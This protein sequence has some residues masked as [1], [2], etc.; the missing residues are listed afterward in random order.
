MTDT[1]QSANTII[2]K[3]T[4]EVRAQARYLDSIRMILE[5]A[6]RLD[7]GALLDA[8]DDDPQYA[9][10]GVF[11]RVCQFEQHWAGRLTT[12]KDLYQVVGWSDLADDLVKFNDV[13]DEWRTMCGFL[14]LRWYHLPVFRVV[15]AGPENSP[16]WRTT[17]AVELMNAIEAVRDRCEA[18]LTDWN[19]DRRYDIDRALL[20]AVC[21][22]RDLAQRYQVATVVDK[23]TNVKYTRL[24]EHAMVD[25][26]LLFDLDACT[27]AVEAWCLKN[28]VQKPVCLEVNPV[29]HVEVVI[30]GAVGPVEDVS[31]TQ[32]ATDEVVKKDE[33]EI[34]GLAPG[35]PRWL[36]IDEGAT[37]RFQMPGGEFTLPKHA[38]E[39]YLSWFVRHM[40]EEIRALRLVAEVRGMGV[41]KELGD[42][43]EDD[44]D[45][46][47]TNGSVNQKGELHP[48][49]VDSVISPE[50]LDGIRRQLFEILAERERCET[51]GNQDRVSK[52]T[53]EVR[54]IEDYLHA[55]VNIR[56]KSRKWSSDD[57][58]A[59]LSI[60]KELSRAYGRVEKGAGQRD[61]REA[62]L[63]HFKDSLTVGYMCKYHAVEGAVVGVL[64]K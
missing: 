45:E 37:Y 63:K 25:R 44:G 64:P 39:K 61:A 49:H 53:E 40:D 54:Q 9:E 36:F 41:K 18:Y 2:D 31:V 33:P 23:L 14:R 10:S 43:V 30:A 32:A 22:L 8:D 7:L 4:V 57:K 47:V 5:G 15:S 13:S 21:A 55:N 12:M 17:L 27:D 38:G 58:K 11:D 3:S 28:G 20:I 59:V 60:Q 24:T 16:E 6:E 52:L 51:D 29:D 50:A 34:K 19:W 26:L 56:G 1:A 46:D 48:V 62:F 42:Y 35:D